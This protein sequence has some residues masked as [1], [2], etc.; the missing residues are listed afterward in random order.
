MVQDTTWK[1]KLV[2]TPVP[3][4]LATMIHVAVNKPILSEFVLTDIK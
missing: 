3:I 1:P 4:I 2:N